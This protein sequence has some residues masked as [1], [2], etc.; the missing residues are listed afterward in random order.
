MYTFLRCLTVS[1][2]FYSSIGDSGSRLRVLYV[3]SVARHIGGF[4]MLRTLVCLY[5]VLW[6]QTQCHTEYQFIVSKFE[7]RRASSTASTPSQRSLP[8]V[9]LPSQYS[10]QHAEIM[11][12]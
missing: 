3:K 1:S 10:E 2:N 8:G 9:S 12:L 4:A 7:N 5:V 6:E 11:A